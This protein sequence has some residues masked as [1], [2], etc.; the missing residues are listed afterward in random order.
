MFAAAGIAI[1]RKDGYA[2]FHERNRM[3]SHPNVEP[4]DRVCMPLV[5]SLMYMGYWA[6]GLERRLSPPPPPLPLGAA[7][8][9]AA[10]F[11]GC[12]TLT[13]GS[14]L[15]NKWF[16]SV[17]RLQSERGHRVVSSGPYAV[18]RHPGYTGF[19]ASGRCGSLAACWRQRLPALR[20]LAE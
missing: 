11:V 8:A 4:F 18:V 10:V 13:T 14:M 12:V 15:A 9:A 7:A 3:L 5:V 16:S 2:L 1:K 17:V 20:R 6:A 19:L